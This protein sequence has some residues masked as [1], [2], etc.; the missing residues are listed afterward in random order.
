MVFKLTIKNRALKI[1][2]YMPLSISVVFTDFK[3]ALCGLKLACPR[4]PLAKLHVCGARTE[5]VVYNASVSFWVWIR[6]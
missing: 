4:K 6:P 3:N 5:R 2:A 1:L